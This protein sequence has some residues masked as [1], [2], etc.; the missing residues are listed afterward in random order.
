MWINIAKPLGKG[1]IMCLTYS[2]SKEELD[3]ISAQEF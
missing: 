3:Y 1:W 2:P